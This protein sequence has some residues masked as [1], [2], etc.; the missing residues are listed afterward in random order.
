MKLNNKVAFITVK[1]SYI[2]SF[3][4]MA[5]SYL[6]QHIQIFEEKEAW[7]VLKEKAF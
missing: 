1:Y 7:H 4:Y 2:L 3:L 5:L 6:N